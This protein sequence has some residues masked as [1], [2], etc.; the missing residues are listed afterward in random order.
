MSSSYFY[1]IYEN[2]AQLNLDVATLF[3]ASL[4]SCVIDVLQERESS[5]NF[6]EYCW[7]WLCDS[8]TSRNVDHPTIPVQY[9]RLGN[10]E[11]WAARLKRTKMG[12]T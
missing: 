10:T 12:L 9:V 11:E 7:R 8:A 2:P 4:I 6:R 1:R 3:H 5:L